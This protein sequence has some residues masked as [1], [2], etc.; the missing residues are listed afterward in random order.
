MK[1]GK[2]LTLCCVMFLCFISF[3][4]SQ[5]YAYLDPGTGSMVVQ[6]VI[7]ALAAA[8]VAFSVF[9]RKLRAFVARIFGREKNSKDED[10]SQL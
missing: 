9:R 5:A 2:K 10:I 1:R 7:A 4:L 6:A 8:G 3:S